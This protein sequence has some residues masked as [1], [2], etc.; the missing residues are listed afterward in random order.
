MIVP[1]DL[2]YSLNDPGYSMYKYILIHNFKIII[3]LMDIHGISK[4][5]TVRRNVELKFGG[6]MGFARWAPRNHSRKKG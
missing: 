6:V 1:T 5:F 4:F 2:P 3:L